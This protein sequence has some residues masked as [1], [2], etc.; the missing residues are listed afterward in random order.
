MSAGVCVDVLAGRLSSLVTTTKVDSVLNGNM[1]SPLGQCLLTDI[2]I[3]Y[4]SAQLLSH[5]R[6]G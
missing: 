4:K 2:L 5:K 6:R 3:L 1:V